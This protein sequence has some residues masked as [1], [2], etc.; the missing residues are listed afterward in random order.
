VP[1]IKVHNNALNNEVVFDMI[2]IRQLVC[3]QN[4]YLN[5]LLSHY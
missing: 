1:Q 5:F 3:R 2:Y 4:F